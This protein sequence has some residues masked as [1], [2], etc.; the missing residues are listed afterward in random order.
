MQHVSNK[1]NAFEFEEKMP[2]S[3]LLLIVAGHLRS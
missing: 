1:A 3:W 2:I